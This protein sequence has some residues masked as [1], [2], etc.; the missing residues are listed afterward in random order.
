MSLCLYSLFT[1]PPLTTSPLLSI[2]TSTPPAFMM[3]ES[4]LAMIWV[5]PTLW[6]ISLS[7]I[8]CIVLCAMIPNESDSI[9]ATFLA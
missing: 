5:S 1:S 3:T 2:T 8:V 9:L 6:V 7:A 4:P